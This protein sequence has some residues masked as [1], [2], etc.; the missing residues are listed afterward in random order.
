MERNQQHQQLEIYRQLQL[1]AALQYTYFS[2]HIE[3]LPREAS[4]DDKNKS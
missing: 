3:H 4:Q 2:V 1:I